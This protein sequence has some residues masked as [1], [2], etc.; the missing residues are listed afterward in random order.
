MPLPGPAA[1]PP[2]HRH[3]HRR[4]RGARP[5]SRRLWAPRRAEGRGERAARGRRGAAGGKG[6]AGSAG[7]V[8]QRVEHAAGFGSPVLDV[9]AGRRRRCGAPGEQAA[10]PAAGLGSRRSGAAGC[11][12]GTH[13][14]RRRVETRRPAAPSSGGRFSPLLRSSCLTWG[15][16]PGNRMTGQKLQLWQLSGSTVLSSCAMLTP[17]APG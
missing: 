10:A 3:R 11:L 9:M 12:P 1:L 16:K 8:Q 13:L 14:V 5:Q 7:A 17:K 15:R 4:L 6:G 2:R